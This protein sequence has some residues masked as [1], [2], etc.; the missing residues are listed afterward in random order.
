MIYFLSNKNELLIELK[1]RQV[2]G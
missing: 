2:S 1:E